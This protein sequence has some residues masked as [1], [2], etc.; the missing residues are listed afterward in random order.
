VSWMAVTYEVLPMYLLAHG[1]SDRMCPEWLI[2][3]GGICTEGAGPNRSKLALTHSRGDRRP[4]SV[5]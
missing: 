5:P 4:A 3:C 1:M 2:E